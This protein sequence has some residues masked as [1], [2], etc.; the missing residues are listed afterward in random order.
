M[1][2]FFKILLNTRKKFFQNHWNDGNGIISE[3]AK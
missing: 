2:E 3:K 1:A